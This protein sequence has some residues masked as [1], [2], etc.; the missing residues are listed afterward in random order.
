MKGVDSNLV[1]EFD[2]REQG[3]MIRAE[4][5]AAAVILEL[6]QA[7]DLNARRA[8]QLVTKSAGWV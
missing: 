2:S 3:M 1:P 4:H 8:A 5:S 6:I 7:C